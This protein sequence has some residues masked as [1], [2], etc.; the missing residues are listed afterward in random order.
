MIKIEDFVQVMELVDGLLYKSMIDETNMHET[1]PDAVGIVMIYSN[2]KLPGLIREAMIFSGDAAERS[3]LID[4]LER[5]NPY[6]DPQ[7]LTW[8]VEDKL[9]T[10]TRTYLVAL[11]LLR[12]LALDFV[13]GPEMTNPGKRLL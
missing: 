1:I 12:R 13:T 8:F 9:F 4:Q 10:R 5:E 3:H 2:A 6:R 11:D 7:I